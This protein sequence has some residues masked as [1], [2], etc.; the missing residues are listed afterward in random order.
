MPPAVEAPGR[1][2]GTLSNGYLDEPHWIQT[3]TIP[4]SHP[5]LPPTKALLP[6]IRIQAQQQVSTDSLS[7][8][9]DAT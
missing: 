7:E 4:S 3:D 2:L 5:S 6:N 9:R 1:A 8:H